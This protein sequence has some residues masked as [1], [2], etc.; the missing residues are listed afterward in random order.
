MYIDTHYM[1]NVE[2]ILKI[3][4]YLNDYYKDI[5]NNYYKGVS[6]S[7]RPHFNVFII[8]CENYDYSCHNIDKFPAIKRVCDKKYS[9]DDG[10]IP[11]YLNIT[12]SLELGNLAEEIEI[13]LRKEKIKKL[14]KISS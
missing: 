10:G 11:C 6:K 12:N 9:T 5:Y 3:N 13:E 8:H 1:R 4:T 7:K 2:N 14:I